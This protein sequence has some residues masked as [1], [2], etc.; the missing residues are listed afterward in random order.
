MSSFLQNNDTMKEVQI[1]YDH[2]LLLC[3]VFL[4]YTIHCC[5][6]FSM[7]V[8]IQII[9]QAWHHCLT[10]DSFKVLLVIKIHLNKIWILLT[11]M[12]TQWLHS[13]QKCHLLLW[14]KKNIQGLTKYQM[15]MTESSI[16][17]KKGRKK[18]R[19]VSA[20]LS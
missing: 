5:F 12:I 7:A 9:Y 11:V 13:M 8:N 16:F 4:L 14:E 2:I 19:N 10:A 6:V 1:S 18:Y 15:E 3:D 20:G 17:F